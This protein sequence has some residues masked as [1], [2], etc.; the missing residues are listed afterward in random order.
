MQPLLTSLRPQSLSS[1]LLRPAF[2]HALLTPM[3]ILLQ[4]PHQILIP[5]L[6][7]ACRPQNHFG[8]N[9]GQI[10]SLLRQ[11]VDRF[12]SVPRIRRGCDYP[13]LLQ[14]SQPVRQ[15][16][17][18]DSLVRF[19]ELLEGGKPTHH[20]VPHDQQ[21]PPVSQHLNRHIQRTPRPP[22]YDRQ[23]LCAHTLKITPFTCILQVTSAHSGPLY[24]CSPNQLHPLQT[25]SRSHHVDC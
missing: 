15:D 7:M 18:S 25:N 8:Q 24:Q 3:P 10:N 2:P 16:I 13:V 6:L 12:P 22:L 9:R 17:G 23:P 1:P 4:R 14:P 21:R 19:H 5:H 20:H 11:P